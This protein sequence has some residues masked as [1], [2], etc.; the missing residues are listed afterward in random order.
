MF[1][2]EISTI[3]EDRECGWTVLIDGEPTRVGKLEIVH[4]QYGT[5]SYGMRP[6]GYDGWAFAENGG[7]GSIS[8]PF[9]RSPEGELLVG[10]ILEPRLNMGGKRWC[11]IGGFK[12]PGESPLSAAIRESFEEVG[13]D[14][15]DRIV[16]LE[17]APGNFNR[18]FSVSDPKQ[19]QGVH[20]FGAKIPFALL[21]KY[22]DGY[23][24]RQDVSSEDRKALLAKGD[25]HVRFVP[26]KKAA[27]Q[28]ADVLFSHALAQ[29]LAMEL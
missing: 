5:L 23:G 26:W 9:A 15:S 6:E 13:Y 4:E 8:I 16:Q 22:E 14:F 11:A 1:N 25:G 10:F 7:G 12:E 29:L 28:C 17:G 18:L 2:F 20:A 19:D 21:E 24:F 3:P 27:L